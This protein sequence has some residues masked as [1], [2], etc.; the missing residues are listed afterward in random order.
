MKFSALERCAVIIWAIEHYRA[1]LLIGVKFMAAVDFSGSCN[2]LFLM[3][4]C[5]RK[6]E[7]L[8]SVS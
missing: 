5:V 2:V 7:S 8:N 1:Q 6:N 4:S 3:S